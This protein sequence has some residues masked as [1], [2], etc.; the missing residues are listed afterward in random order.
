MKDARPP[1]MK[2][3]SS[4]LLLTLFAVVCLGAQPGLAQSS[5]PPNSFCR[6]GIGAANGVSGYDLTQL[7]VGSYL[8]WSTSRSSQVPN[9]I[10]FFHVLRVSDA[11]YTQ[12]LA[13]L[14][15]QVIANPGA[16]WIIGNEPD[17]EVSYQDHVTA[18][19]YAQRYFELATLIRAKDPEA[20]IG[21]APIIQPTP[22]R[23]YYLDLVLVEL[24]QLTSNPSAL[25]DVFT[26]HNFLLNEQPIYQ[27][28]RT[29]SWGAGVPLGYVAGVWPEPDVITIGGPND[30]T[31]NTHSP[32]IFAERIRAF[33][34]WMNAQDFRNKPLWITEFGSLFPSVSSLY[35]T[36]SE[37]D[38]A[39]FL[40]QTMD[41]MLTAKDG[42]IGYSPDDNR[43][44][45]HFVWY[46]LNEDRTR[47]G[48][49]LYDPNNQQL[50]L[51][52]ER[53]L[54]YDPPAGA[55]LPSKPAD[56]YVLPDSL[57]I[58]PTGRANGPGLVNYRVMVRA[59]NAIA[60]EYRTQVR[61]RL[62]QNGLVVGEKTA[63][64]PRCSG[65]TVFRFDLAA[66]QAG[67]RHTLKVEISLL[68]GNGPETNLANDHRTFPEITL[69]PIYQAILPVINR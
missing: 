12:T 49:S 62:Y 29:V 42:A 37:A 26:I 44:V 54:N 46:S 19:V 31:K 61:A 39:S 30:Q 1:M 45:Q 33:R 69:P 35:L 23:I 66:Q 15:T 2:W 13:N 34:S 57:I 32:A 40:Q 43:L 52:G 65:H 63:P 18:Q 5:T 7:G 20:V 28:G 17:S 53:F 47:F 56:L 8:D 10:Q 6:F 27:N 51:V 16:V 24:N 41:F 4:I 21:F 55:L 25:I 48:G 67:S 36:V 22:L 38:T 68:S 60:S 11:S 59:S 3:K 9:T 50:T 58:G 14:P 64:L